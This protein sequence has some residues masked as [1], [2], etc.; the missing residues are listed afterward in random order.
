MKY[1]IFIIMTC[2]GLIAAS[3]RGVSYD[4][5]TATVTQT[6]LSMTLSN[7]TVTSKLHVGSSA[8][9]IG[10]ITND[11]LQS[12][13]LVVA[14]GASQLGSVTS[15][16]VFGAILQDG[17]G[18]TTGPSFSGVIITDQTNVHAGNITIDDTVN[19]GTSG[20]PGTIDL[21]STNGTY[22]VT[23]TVNADGTFNVSTNTIF[24]GWVS[25]G[26][27]TNVLAR[28]GNDLLYTNGGGQVYITAVNGS[29]ATAS[30]GLTTGG[31]AVLTGSGGNTFLGADGVTYLV[32]NSAALSP[33]TPGNAPLSLGTDSSGGAFSNLWLKGT[34]E[35]VGAGAGTADYS[36][37]A[38]SHDGT[39]ILFDSQSGGTVT[40]SGHFFFLSN[41]VEVAS[42]LNTGAL[43]LSSTTNQLS[44]DGSQLLYNGSPI[45]GGNVVNTGTS[46][47]GTVPTYTSTSGTAISPTLAFLWGDANNNLFFTSDT[48]PDV[49][50]SSDMI[51]IGHGIFGGSALTNT[52]QSVILIG[53]N[54]FA[55]STLDGGD[56]DSI[57]SIGNS[58][59]NS[60]SLIHFNDIVAL[61]ALSLYN[62]QFTAGAEVISLGS[63]A[64]S[65][66]NVDSS[67]NLDFIGNNS[68]N[69]TTILHG[70]NIS[71]YGKSALQ[72]AILTN[73]TGITA[74]G[75]G[76]GAN[77]KLTNSQQ[78]ILIGADVGFD[79]ST[80][81]YMAGENFNNVIVIGNSTIA[82]PGAN[83]TT[84]GNIYTMSTIL[85]GGDLKF[86][87]AAYLNPWA[88]DG[89]LPY[90][91]NTALAHTSGN[92]LEMANDGTNVL[93]VGFD[94]A[95]SLLDPVSG[96][97][98][99]TVDDVN[100][101]VTRT[102]ADSTI[103][104]IIAPLYFALYKA[105][106]TPV[107][108]YTPNAA[109]GLTPYKNDTVLTHN[110]GNLSEQGN[111]GTNVM[112]VTYNGAITTTDPSAAFVLSDPWQLGKQ[113]SAV[114]LTLVA[115]NYV[116]VT[117]GGVTVKLA[118]VQ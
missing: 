74:I 38:I 17:G 80:G 107:T 60:S 89:V 97:A 58:V 52:P 105:G 56:T 59:G 101:V 57:I 111:N 46:Q 108:E 90:Y 51:G 23:L 43:T 71:G 2:A 30:V 32:L 65:S 81:D 99:L 88:V 78:V 44:D 69:S 79:P 6:D 3:Q 22:I 27:L 93:T 86:G 7:A 66:A 63:F 64:L 67:D 91:L 95:L 73:V 115:T 106:G 10:A 25:F 29:G 36:R 20:S 40:E 12:H 82:P 109:D 75:A 39:N 35:I 16:G 50:P 94:G 118:T 14:G 48:P 45:V 84:I 114:A 68:G 9:I 26:G 62:S 98:Y 110:S 33:N 116:E 83:T 103:Q 92:L 54:V 8:R 13:E 34:A 11:A 19:I 47:I 102:T 87:S 72:G 4:P 85:P 53:P 28:N 100:G 77:V 61:G 42:I 21:Y 18:P 70:H 37:L 112:Q 104:G 76:A 1:L 113:K 49:S 55:S 96:V 15:S 24:Q 31:S 117:I 41:G 5:A